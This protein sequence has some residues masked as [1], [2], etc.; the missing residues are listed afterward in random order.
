MLT[1][2]CGNPDVA[3]DLAQDTLVRACLHWHRVREMRDPRAWLNR[4]ALNMANSRWRRLRA[5]RHAVTMIAART[6]EVHAEKDLDEALAVRAAVAAL[7]PR[8]RTAVILRYYQDHDVP[9][10]AELM[11]CGEGTVKKLTARGLATLRSR[12]DLP[13][14]VGGRP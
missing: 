13:S 2:Y 11:R 10:T 5:E 6:G 4:V 9:Q 8:Q 14:R 12:L 1:L 3:A 7:T